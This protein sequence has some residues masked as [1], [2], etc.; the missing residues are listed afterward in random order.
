MRN[1]LF[2][3]TLGVVVAVGATVGIVVVSA[4]PD[5]P[6][7][8]TR[9]SGFVPKDFKGKW[10]G[11]WRN[12]TFGSQGD[13]IANIKAT[14]TEFKP[15]ADF[16]GGAFGCG[17]SGNV[18][19]IT[20]KKGTGNNKWSKRGFKIFKATSQFGKLTFEYDQK[21]GKVTGSGNSPC[22]PS[23]TFTLDGK[24]TKRAFSATVDITISP[25]LKPTA[26]LEAKKN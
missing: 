5:E 19:A 16:S 11:T 20:L 14:D 4:D 21:T 12:T 22:E 24:L 6:A 8:P 23:T 9:A 7:A 10:T 2:V 18:D 1:R 3:A 17:E 13:I 26:E 25:N 15:L